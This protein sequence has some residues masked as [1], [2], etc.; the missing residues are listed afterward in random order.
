MAGESTVG[1]RTRKRKRTTTQ[2]RVKPQPEP[3][4]T[5][6]T[7]NALAELTTAHDRA[8]TAL[9]KAR[10]L[11]AEWAKSPHGAGTGLHRSTSRFLQYEIDQ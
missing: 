9:G 8:L 5:G 3:A 11:L 10:I 6:A 4:D 1:K 2:R 7:T